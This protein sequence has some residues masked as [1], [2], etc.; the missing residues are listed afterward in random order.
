MADVVL[1]RSRGGRW[2][3]AEPTSVDARKLART[4]S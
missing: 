4:R 1:E 3:M 2:V